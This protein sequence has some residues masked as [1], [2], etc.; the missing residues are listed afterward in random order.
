MRIYQWQ[1]I[2]VGVVLLVY[3]HTLGFPFRFYDEDIIYKELIF[4]ISH[5]VWELGTYIKEFGLMVHFEASSVF[6]SKLSNLRCNP[7]NTFITMVVQML[8]QKQAFLYHALSLI[9]H[10]LNS[11][12]LFKV[13]K[14]MTENKTL[15]FL[16]TLLWAL[17]PLN[18]ESVVFATNWASLLS[19]L[20]AF[21][22]FYLTVFCEKKWVPVFLLSLFCFFN[23]E[24]V[25]MLPLIIQLYLY[26]KQ[27]SPLKSLPVWLAF[28]I[29][30]I[31]FVLS[32]GY[33]NLHQEFVFERLLWFV[34]Q[35]LVH[36]ILLVLFPIHLSLDQS[37]TVKFALE[38]INPYSIACVL[39]TIALILSLFL[40]G[41]MR[42]ILLPALIAAVPFLHII[43]PLYN[44][45][46]ER[47]FYFPLFFLV[48]GLAAVLNNVKQKAYVVPLLS[49]LL[50][51]L[52]LRAYIR[53]YDW[54]DNY[55][56]FLSTLKEAPNDL[57]RGLRYATLAGLCG[58]TIQQGP[59]CKEYLDRSLKYLDAVLDREERPAVNIIK[60]YGVDDATAK[61]KATYIKGFLGLSP[62]EKFPQKIL[63]P[64]SDKLQDSQ[65]FA[66]YL[67]YLLQTNQLDEA[68][69]MSKRLYKLK[70]S[71]PILIGLS[72]VEQKKYKNLEK[73]EEY[74]L[75]AFDLFKY[76][77]TV[78]QELVRF[79]GDTNQ[80]IKH[81]RF[82]RLYMM[83]NHVK[84]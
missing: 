33:S 49:C 22:V 3:I 57:Y 79:Y 75:Q 45:V 66:L 51:L 4:P 54:R 72:V 81:D 20:A 32:P 26:W 8:F 55:T 37:A 77:Q 44:I 27:Q 36:N 61:I 52:S 5:N 34:P 76:D 67:A 82:F 48:I 50:V 74:L 63:Q 18:V 62:G 39:Y 25:I 84:Y 16:C 30:L 35:V 46:S 65:M 47:Y 73:A 1:L 7:V 40:F 14:K 60:Y 64:Y 41:S 78:L 69:K 56:L 17:N 31:Y 71:P 11:L 43:S 70:V 12:L 10:I 19:S 9:L 38:L 24:H 2:I 80:V 28:L 83:R 15:S 21:S 68:E 53:S 13:I 23:T 6:Y 58:Q 42:I 29:Y 59:H